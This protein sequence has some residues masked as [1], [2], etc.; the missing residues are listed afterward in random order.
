MEV[1][2]KKSKPHTTHD[3]IVLLSGFINDWRSV[4][5]INFFIRNRAIF[6][7]AAPWLTAV[8]RSLRRSHGIFWQVSLFYHSLLSWLP[9]L[10]HWREKSTYVVIVVECMNH[11]AKTKYEWLT[12]MTVI[13]CMKT[14]YW[15]LMETETNITL[16]LHQW[17]HSLVHPIFFSFD[18]FVVQFFNSRWNCYSLLNDR[19]S[20][21]AR[22]SFRVQ[23]Y[24]LHY[25]W[26][27][28]KNDH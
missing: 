21:S 2:K 26:Q 1:K 18:K 6:G 20:K 28:Q 23:F 8:W 27:E 24:C 15:S 4:I 22:T 16:M 13:R 9:A 25:S 12:C 3:K 14:W 7:L 17:N 19:R 11:I 5:F 10:F